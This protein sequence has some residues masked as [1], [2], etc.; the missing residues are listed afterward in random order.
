[1]PKAGTSVK[2]DQTGPR[3][4]TIS[5]FSALLDGTG[6]RPPYAVGV[7]G[8]GDSMGLLV[9][10]V[11]S[12]LA[13]SGRVTALTVDHGLRSD[14]RREAETVADWCQALGVPHEI[15]TWDGPKPA[16]N[17]QAQ[18][19]DARYR[20]M[21]AWC[22][23]RRVPT[24]LIAHTLE[25]QAETVLLRLAR[26]SGVDGLSAMAP[27][28]A[29][30][31]DTNSDSVVLVRPLLTVSRA[32]LR[33]TLREAGQAWID[34]P[35]N[36]DAQFARVRVRALSKSLEN[37]GIDADRLSRTAAHM[38]RVREALDHYAAALLDDAAAIHPSGFAF[39]NREALTA[40]PRETA[41]RALSV[42]LRQIG[43]R[44]APLR[45]ER[46]ERLFGQITKPD[47]EAACTLS[48]C[49]LLPQ[50]DG[51]LLVVR[52]ARNL[53]DPILIRPGATRL[54]DN[55]MRIG[56]GTC[57]RAGTVEALGETGWLQIRDEISDT[58]KS[59]IPAE[60]R[61]TLP[62]FWRD[63]RVACVPALEFDPERSEFSAEFAA[64]PHFDGLEGSFG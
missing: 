33:Q 37:E 9:L 54:W 63:R 16:A 44:V 26:G 50:P 38:A 35:S 4:I 48:G 41:L 31:D 7:S 47:M 30:P 53:P 22:R 10:L 55:R 18:A 56:L 59:T 21:G 43:G 25:D 46:L 36:E 60:A 32:R 15:L 51:R 28:A 6:C 62:A 3:P 42:L 45:F 39:L 5:E 34:D 64:M 57:A 20:L 13:D 8:G 29:L 14:S 61:H 49:C 17:I 27:V 1:M 23:E 58:I 11:Q 40:A 12:G 2:A 19:R 24:L 52:E